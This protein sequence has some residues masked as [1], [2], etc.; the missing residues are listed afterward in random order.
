VLNA[1][2]AVRITADCYGKD[3][4]EAVR[5]AQSILGE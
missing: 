4:M 5:F 1:E 3:A 2:Y